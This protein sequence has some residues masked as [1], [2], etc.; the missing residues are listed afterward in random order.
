M[1]ALAVGILIA[2]AWPA[3]AETLKSVETFKYAFRLSGAIAQARDSDT[4]PGMDS[5]EGRAVVG[6]AMDRFDIDE[7]AHR[8]RSRIQA[9][10]PESEAGECADFIQSPIGAAFL[11]AMEPARDQAEAERR[12][13]TLPGTYRAPIEGFI[14]SACYQKA[15]ALLVSPAVMQAQHEYGTDLVCSEFR[16]R[17]AVAHAQ[18]VRRGHCRP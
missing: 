7:L 10:L 17:D 3:S 4:F 6:R 1:K 16:E 2:F 8:V 11:E 13:R 5:A 15:S 14:R 9:S 18:A 12:L